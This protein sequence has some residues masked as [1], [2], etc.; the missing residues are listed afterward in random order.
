MVLAGET[1]FLAPVGD[2]ETIAAYLH[3]LATNSELRHRL[4]E[5]G[6]ARA[7]EM[8][9]EDR[10]VEEYREIYWET[11]GRLRPNGDRR[12]RPFMVQG[13]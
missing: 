13:V 2:P 11:L 3:K 1:G 4:G 5:A 6:R 9:A 10:M 12:L 7:W 8:F